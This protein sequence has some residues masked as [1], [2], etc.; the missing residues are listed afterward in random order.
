MLVTVELPRGISEDE[1][2][3]WLAMGVRE[4]WRDTVDRLAAALAP[5]PGAIGSSGRQE[6]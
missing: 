1:A 4:G 6:A 5:I 3:G 2:R